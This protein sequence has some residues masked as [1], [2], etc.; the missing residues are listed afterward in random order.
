MRTAAALS[1]LALLLLVAGLA[2][3]VPRTGGVDDPQDSRPLFEGTEFA[4]ASRVT[5]SY[6]PDDG[7]L[8]A[9]LALVAPLGTTASPGAS[10]FADLTFGVGATGPGG[11]CAVPDPAGEGRAGDLRVAAT[12]DSNGPP[13]A[14]TDLVRTTVQVVGGPQLVGASGAISADRR[15]I[16]WT[17][18][19]DPALAGRDLDCVG[20][21]AMPYSFSDSDAIA[22]FPLTTPPDR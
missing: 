12:I 17:V 13:G 6:E 8:I 1:A 20:D 10:T 15:V 18:A 3:A 5:V 2:T 14:I 21:V 22:G 7:T 16:T 4:D 11:V 19:P 9:T